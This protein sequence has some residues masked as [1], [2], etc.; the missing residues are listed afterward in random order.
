MLN[1]DKKSLHT[2]YHLQLLFFLHTVQYYQVSV[3]VIKVNLLPA[4]SKK[5]TT[6]FTRPLGSFNNKKICHL[7][8][9]K[10][11]IRNRHQYPPVYKY[12]SDRESRSGFRHDDDGYCEPK[13]TRNGLMPQPMGPGTH[14]Q[15]A[16]P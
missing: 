12:T 11:N 14:T 8:C 16:G 2:Y 13:V 5:V 1:I 3:L 9:P 6:R 10:Q 7:N 15:R 4:S